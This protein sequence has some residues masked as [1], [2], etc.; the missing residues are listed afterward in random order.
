MINWKI[1]RT[2]LEISSFILRMSQLFYK[3]FHFYF[4]VKWL[5]IKATGR[6]VL[7]FWPSQN[8]LD[9]FKTKW[10]IDAN[11]NWLWMC[12]CY[13]ICPHLDL[14]HIIILPQHSGDYTLIGF[15]KNHP[16]TLIIRKM[17]SYLFLLLIWANSYYY[18]H[19]LSS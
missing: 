6:F 3:I 18:L 9:L 14:S 1:R 17:N 12:M 11:P 15:N 13:I 10:K 4:K 7:F 8:K 19:T 2:S 5:T 16:E